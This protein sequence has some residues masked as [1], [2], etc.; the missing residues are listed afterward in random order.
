M[1]N[2]HKPVISPNITLPLAFKTIPICITVLIL[3]TIGEPD[4]LDAIIKLIM[5]FAK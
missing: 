3:F 2:P 4:L 5:S 1:L